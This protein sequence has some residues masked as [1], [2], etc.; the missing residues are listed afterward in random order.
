MHETACLMSSL[1][2][3]APTGMTAFALWVG[4][5][6]LGHIPSTLTIRLTLR[7]RYGASEVS[8]PFLKSSLSR[9]RALVTAG[10]PSALAIEGMLY[11]DKNDPAAAIR[12]IERALSLDR[13]GS[14][15]R[16]GCHGVLG[17][18]YVKVGRTEEGVKHLRMAVNEQ[19]MPQYGEPLSKLVQDKDEAW[20]LL[21]K[22]ACVKPSLFAHLADAEVQRAESLSDKSGRD[23]AYKMASEWS[24]LAD[25]NVSC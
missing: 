3:A 24:R 4:A 6:E 17:E 21:Y 16:T 15:W 5:S 10:N 7:Y 18:M 19:H 23:E 14:V 20:A 25:P 1:K 12:T 2:T 22:A 9:F 11:A 8:H 13:D